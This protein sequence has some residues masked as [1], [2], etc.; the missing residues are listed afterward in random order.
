[1]LIAG[2]ILEGCPLAWSIIEDGRRLAIWA[3]RYPQYYHW[4]E[5]IGTT[6][7]VPISFFYAQTTLT[8]EIII[9]LAKLMDENA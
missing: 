4:R 3:L 7:V 1:L 2:H 5:E 6:A 8:T 9:N